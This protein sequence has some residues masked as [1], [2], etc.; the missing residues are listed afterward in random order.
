MQLRST[1]FKY[2]EKDAVFFILVVFRVNELRRQEN[3]KML[4]LY[5]VVI[6][7]NIDRKQFFSYKKPTN[8]NAHTFAADFKKEFW[9]SRPR[10][11][12]A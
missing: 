2:S 8:R 1:S 3:G 4:R 9:K 10:K 11:V 6:T 5:D 12:N 7:D